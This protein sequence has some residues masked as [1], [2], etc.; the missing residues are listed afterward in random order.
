VPVPIQGAI[1]ELF[2]SPG[3]WVSEGEPLARIVD[4][5]RLI[6][7]V[8]VPEAYIGR[9][10]EVSGAWF[11]LDS[12][13][14]TIEVP[15]TAL[16]AVGTELDDATRTL[17]VRFQI[18][19]V[20]RELFAGMTTQAHLI[21]DEPRLTAAVPR[22]SLVDDAGTDVVYV[23]TG[24]ESFERRPVQIGIRDGRFVEVI[25]GVSPN[26]WVVARGAYSIKLASTSTESIGHGH[27]H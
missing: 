27:A 6:L 5:R 26:E 12:L 25:A 1:A 15:Q 10:R 8:G 11:H 18:D 16:I 4:R 20:R 7:S 17:P 24:G 9:I 3:T 23:Q 22:S 13:S 14:E 19:N 2:V 21:A